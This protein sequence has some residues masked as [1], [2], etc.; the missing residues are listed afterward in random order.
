M[1]RIAKLSDVEFQEDCP[2]FEDNAYQFDCGADKS[3]C[4]LYYGCPII[5]KYGDLSV[6]EAVEQLREDADAKHYLDMLRSDGW[7]D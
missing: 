6:R 5:D 4:S 3:T 1:K 7:I 2:F